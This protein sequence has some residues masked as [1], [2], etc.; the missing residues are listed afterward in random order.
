MWLCPQVIHSIFFGVTKIFKYSNS[1]FGRGLAQ[2]GLFRIGT[3]GDYRKSEHRSGVSDIEEGIKLVNVHIESEY[4]QS[5]SEVPKTLAQLGL[6]HCDDTATNITLKDIHTSHRLVAPDAYIWC[7]S[8]EKSAAVM[9]Q[10]EGADTCVE[11]H[12][13]PRFFAILNQMMSSMDADFIG[14]FEVQYRNRTESWQRDSLGI[15]PS[16]IKSIDFKLQKEVRA[17]WVPRHSS[18]I[19]PTHGRCDALASCCKIVSI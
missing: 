15:H 5:G 18:P 19:E 9:S 6:I 13:I 7:A 3:L 2:L 14:I 1:Y 10:F 8:T 17:I 12:N 11:I 16:I 4:F